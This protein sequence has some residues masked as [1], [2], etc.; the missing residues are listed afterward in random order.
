[1][2]RFRKQYGP[3]EARL[4]RERPRPSDD[5]VRG[6]TSDVGAPYTRRSPRL[7][8]ALVLCMTVIFA[9]VLTG[10]IGYAASAVENGTLA[11]KHLLVAKKKHLAVKSAT[12]NHPRPTATGHRENAADDQYGDKVLICHIPPGNPGNAHTIMISASAVPAH[13]AHGDYLGPCKSSK[14]KKHK[15]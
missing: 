7:G 11:V 5:L 15:K 6:I 10:G 1:M 12:E 2:R 3:L 9:F 13:L 14:H 8:V 4:R